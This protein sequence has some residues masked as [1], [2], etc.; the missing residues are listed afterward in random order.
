MEALDADDVALKNSQGKPATRDIV[1]FVP[2]NQFRS[3]PSRLAAHTLKEI[4]GQIEQYMFMNNI[5]PLDNPV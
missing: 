5:K 1:Q 4:P 3:S 2:F